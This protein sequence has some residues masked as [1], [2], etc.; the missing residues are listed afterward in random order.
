MGARAVDALLPVVL[1][2]PRCAR[3]RAYS[4]NKAR[5]NLALLFARE[6]LHSAAAQ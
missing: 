1:L 5:R 4:T 2:R 6:S 3:V